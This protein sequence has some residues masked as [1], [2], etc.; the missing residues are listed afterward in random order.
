VTPVEVLLNASKG[1]KRGKK[2]KEIKNDLLSYMAP[3]IDERCSY[4]TLIDFVSIKKQ[5]LKLLL[6]LQEDYLMVA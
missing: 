5:I 2:E 4:N 1:L 3:L 6:F